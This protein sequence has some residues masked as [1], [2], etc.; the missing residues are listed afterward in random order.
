MLLTGIRDEIYSTVDTCNTAHEMWIAIERTVT[1]AGARETVDSQDTD[2]EDDEQEL[3][4]RYSFMAKIQEVLPADLGTDADPLEKAEQNAKECDDERTA[5][6]NSIANLTLDIEENKKI[7]KQLKKTN[8]SLSQELKSANLLLRRL[9]ELLRSIMYVKSFKKEID[10][11]ESEE[12][13]F[14]NIYDLF[15]QECVSKDIMC[16]YL[17][18]LP[19]LTAQAELQCLYVHKVNECECR[20]EKL[21]KQTK[22]ASITIS[23]RLVNLVMRIWKLLLGNLPKGYAL[24]EGIDFEESFALVARLEAVRIFI[25]Y[26]THKSFLIYQMDVKTNFLNGPLKE[27]VYVAQPDRFVDPD[28]PKK[29]LKFPTIALVLHPTNVAVAMQICSMRKEI[30]KETEMQTQHSRYVA[31]KNYHRIGSLLPKEGPQHRY[32][33]L[34]FF[35]THNEIRN[36]LGA[37]MDNDISE[38]VNETI[39][40]K[41]IKMLD[42]NSAIAK[43]F[44]MAR[45]CC[46]SHTYVN[47]E[48][49]LLFE[50]TNSMQY[51]LPTITEVAA[52]ITKDFGNGEPTRD[53]IVYKKDSR[54]KRIS[55]LHPSY[56]ALQY[57]LLFLWRRW[58]GL[59]HA[60]IL[61]WLKEHYECKT[62]T[63]IDDIISIELPSPTDDPVGYK[64]VTDYMLHGTYGKDAKYVAC[65]VE[66]PTSQE[67][68]VCQNSIALCGMNNLKCGSREKKCNELLTVNRRICATLKEACFSYGLLNDDREWTRAIQE[69]IL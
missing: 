51:N 31:N 53:I 21:S 66:V 20:A 25:A 23:S 3:E 10:E 12:D 58:Y 13:D 9:L 6:A 49:R 57:P 37:F 69:A 43:A 61:L 47:M 4:A 39:V 32:A 24:E 15:L 26:A 7:L 14:S 5:L 68:Y 36:Q 19:D 8:A 18:S 28:L 11:L 63:D 44:R 62:P 27:E 50:R 67:T 48:L 33:Q 38:G 16:S 45:N 56:M 60:R 1:V 55:E 30:T 64:A 17:H 40:G 65:N 46:H 2:E 22:E 34:W 59:P 35:D 52:L 42:Q 29:G 41:L 54:P